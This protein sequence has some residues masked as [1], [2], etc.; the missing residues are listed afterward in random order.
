MILPPPERT[1]SCILHSPFHTLLYTFII[2][3]CTP[4]HTAL[5]LT[6]TQTHTH[7]HPVF[8][9]EKKN[10]TQLCPPYG[11]GLSKPP[12][13]QGAHK[14]TWESHRADAVG[15]PLSGHL[16]APGAWA[17]NGSGTP[18][19]FSLWAQAGKPE[20]RHISQSSDCLL[21][22]MVVKEGFSR[23]IL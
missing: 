17:G 11:S 8:I 6:H 18:V 12:A 23:L 13:D 16:L 21:F 7:T 19:G 9:F 4:Q 20:Y 1:L 14:G 2:D 10:P 5:I 3:I 15:A 22:L